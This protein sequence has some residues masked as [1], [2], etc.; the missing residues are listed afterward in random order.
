MQLHHP[1]PLVQTQ[2]AFSWEG[3]TENHN[4]NPGNMRSEY[5]LYIWVTPFRDI[6]KPC[7]GRCLSSSAGVEPLWPL[8]SGS[9]ENVLCNQVWI[10]SCDMWVLCLGYS[11]LAP[12]LLIAYSPLSFN[13]FNSYYY[14]LAQSI[15]KV[16]YLHS[17]TYNKHV[18]FKLLCSL[19]FYRNQENAQP[20]TRYI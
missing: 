8:S 6:P 20:T 10:S 17:Y 15:S 1:P 5:L 2:W 4:L 19:F 12:N 18:F 14:S 11:S 9:Q 7:Q 13:L 3:E 16:M